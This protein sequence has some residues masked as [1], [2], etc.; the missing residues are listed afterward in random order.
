MTMLA[1]T[2]ETTR[3]SMGLLAACLLAVAW[4][5]RRSLVDFPKPQRWVSL[6]VR[7]I[8]LVLLV[9]AVTGLNVVGGDDRQFVVFLVDRSD[10]V[11][12]NDVGKAYRF[13]QASAGTISGSDEAR[14]VEFAG[15]TLPPRRVDEQV[16]SLDGLDRGRTDVASALSVG[17]ASI[18]AFYAKT[19]VVVSDGRATEGDA[20][21]V[22]R[23]ARRAGVRV[24]AVPLETARRDEVQLTSVGAPAQVRTGAS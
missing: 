10:S 18:P 12:A 22:A 4:Y 9:L 19:L 16:D 7:A 2:L 23:A 5:F 14:V 24:C 1:W 17:W 3:P 8:V 6:G 20:L 13:V 21:R 15:N 11:D